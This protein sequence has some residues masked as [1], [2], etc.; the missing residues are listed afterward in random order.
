L[1]A[2]L[3]ESKEGITALE[4]G[5]RMG[6]QEHTTRS[7]ISRNIQNNANFKVIKGKNNIGVTTYRVAKEATEAAA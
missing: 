4:A 3:Q 6:I 2:I 5:K 7:M 1:L